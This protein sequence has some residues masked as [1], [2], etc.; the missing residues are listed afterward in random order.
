MIAA[1][2]KGEGTLPFDLPTTIVSQG[3]ETSQTMTYDYDDMG[4]LKEV[5]Y[6][7]GN[8]D[9]FTYNNRNLLAN[10]TIGNLTT[11][12]YNYNA[13]GNVNRMI[14][15]ESKTYNFNYDGHDR[16]KEVIDPLGNKV[17]K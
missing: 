11:I 17:N 2:N 6:P 13:N 7:K 9:T 8:K 14:D 16:L 12:C 4:N 10:K 5:I 1:A 3:G 15:G